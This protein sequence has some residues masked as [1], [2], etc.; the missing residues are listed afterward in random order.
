MAA[1]WLLNQLSLSGG[2][3]PSITNTIPDRPRRNRFP[4]NYIRSLEQEEVPGYIRLLSSGNS[5]RSRSSSMSNYVVQQNSIR[6]SHRAQGPGFS[7]DHM[8]RSEVPLHQR[9]D[10]HVKSEEPLHLRTDSNSVA[11]ETTNSM[12]GNTL[13]NIRNTHTLSYL[14]SAEDEEKLRRERHMR[15]KEAVKRAKK[16]DE[17][18]AKL[19]HE[20]KAKQNS[21]SNAASMSSSSGGRNGIT[22]S[23]P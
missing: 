18:R 12:P 14:N 15:K 2:Q 6:S 21:S 3:R 9:T 13:D 1:K 17:E 22:L 23:V 10:P 16:R 5:T 19:M 4:G 8:S 11:R 7:L 20:R